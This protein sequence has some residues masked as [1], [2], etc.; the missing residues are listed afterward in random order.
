MTCQLDWTVNS[1]SSGEGVLRTSMAATGVWILYCINTEIWNSFG[2]ETDKMRRTFLVNYLVNWKII[3]NIR[4]YLLKFAQTHVHC[5][6]N[7][8]QPSHPL[9][10]LPSVFP[11]IRIFSNELALHIRWRKY[12]SVCFSISPSDVYSCWFPLGLT[13][14]Q[15]K[16]I[17]RVFSSTTIWKHQFFDA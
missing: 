8:I 3:W 14:L 4:D 9:L 13:G 11:S 7:A 5:V 10:L 6:G 2:Q 1:G 16:G 15:S 12:W 17:S